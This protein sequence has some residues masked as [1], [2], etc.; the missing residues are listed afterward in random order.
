MLEP[1]QTVITLNRIAYQQK[2][3]ISSNGLE[4]MNLSFTALYFSLVS[5]YSKPPA[6]PSGQLKKNLRSA[7]ELWL[8]ETW[9]TEFFYVNTGTDNGTAIR[10]CC[11][12]RNSDFIWVFPPTLELTVN[13]GGNEFSVLLGDL[14]TRS[15]LIDFFRS[16]IV[17]DGFMDVGLLSADFSKCGQSAILHKQHIL[18]L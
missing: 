11:Y 10:P 13:H 12:T 8:E 16:E 17:I 7:G 18:S 3:I 5:H 9:G 2:S 4:I 6:Q 15:D 1:R 14:I